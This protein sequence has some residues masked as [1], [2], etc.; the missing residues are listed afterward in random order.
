MFNDAL[1]KVSGCHSNIM[2][3]TQITL[4]YVNKAILVYQ[5]RFLLFQLKILFQIFFT[6]VLK[7]LKHFHGKALS[8]K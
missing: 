8:W 7:A 3:I 5:V 2:C 4:K 6:Y 1:V